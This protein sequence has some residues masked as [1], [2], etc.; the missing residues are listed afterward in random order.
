MSDT[1]AM[2]HVYHVVGARKEARRHR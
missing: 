2:R 1:E